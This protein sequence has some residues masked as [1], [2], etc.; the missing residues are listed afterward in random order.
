MNK[1]TVRDVDVRGKRCLVRVDV[2]VPMNPG[3]REISDDSR[4]RA[5]LPTIRYLSE[6]DSVV[7]LCAHFD[8]PKGKVVEEMR[9]APVR[10][11]LSELL[12]IEVVDAGGPSGPEPVAVVERLAPGQV[13]LLEN[14]RF[15]P[16][17]EA[18]DPE[19]ARSLASLADI[20]VDDAFGA[21]HRV[22]ASVV[23]VA[24]HLPAVAGFLMQKELEMLGRV[25]DDVTHPAVA[26]IGGAKV[27]DKIQVLV[28]LSERVDTVL[29]GGGMVAAFLRA[30]GYGSGSADISKDEVSAAKGLLDRKETRMMIPQDVIVAKSFS[31]DTDSATVPADAVP[32]DALVLDIGPITQ[33]TYANEIGSARTVIW[34]GPMGVYEWDQFASG[35]RSVANAIAE[36]RDA[37]TVVGGGSTAEAIDSLG[38]R[39]KVTHV[40]TGGGASLEF[41]EGKVLPGVAALDDI[42][43]NRAGEQ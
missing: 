13:A 17:E 32:D 28:N 35:T 38:L 31:A 23:G 8:R 19:F 18:N 4:I 3:A 40:S 24:D 1:K 29:I 37:V 41:L 5:V 15:D 9:L 42:D 12:E 16:G 36:N 2:N 6:H 30:Q 10:K 43:N 25:V 20:Y 26:V 21:A 27:A 11:R 7:I 14:L 39:D 22:H 33:D 34:N